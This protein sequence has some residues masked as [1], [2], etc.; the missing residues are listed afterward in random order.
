MAFSWTNINNNE[1]ALSVRNK[2]NTLGTDYASNSAKIDEI[3]GLSTQVANLASVVAVYVNVECP[4]A[5]WV[6]DT[7]A[8]YENYPYKADLYIAGTT[9]DMIPMVNF[10]ATEQESGNFIGSETGTNIVTIWAQEI[11]SASFT[12]PNVVLLKEA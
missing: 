5:Q 6:Q 9:S 8:T 10:G 4:V 7:G 12:I 2:I 3:D 11:P 1:N